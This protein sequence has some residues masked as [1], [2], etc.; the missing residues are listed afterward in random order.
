MST[1]NS[2]I[3]FPLLIWLHSSLVNY[4]ETKAPPLKA[5]FS[6]RIF[7]PVMLTAATALTVY[8]FLHPPQRRAVTMETDGF[9]FF[10]SC[11]LLSCIG[12]SCAIPVLP[13]GGPPDKV[14]PAIVES[15]PASE[16]VNVS[17]D[18]IRI[19]FS[20]FVDQASFAQSVSMTPAFDRPLQYRW[21]KKRVDITFPESL[22]ENTTYILNIDT[23]L[24][25]VNRIA[26]T[27]PITLAFAT[28]PIINR[29]RITGRVI[30]PQEGAGV[31][32]FDVFA[33]A[34]TDATL[35]DSLPPSPAYRTQTDEKGAFKFD[36][37][38][39]QAYFVIA[40]QDRNRNRKPDGL[41]AFAVPPEPVLL[42][43]S[44]GT[45]PSLSWLVTR[46]DTIPPQLQRIRSISNQRFMLRFS[47]SVQLLSR[48]PAQWSLKDSVSN[49]AYTIEDVYLYPEDPKQVY[50]KTP[51]LFA[52]THLLQPG[53]IA[54]SSGNPV[55]ATELTFKP[56]ANSDTLQL[57]F[58][59]F[60][61]EKLTNNEL[62]AAVLSP[63][64]RAGIRF[65]QSLCMGEEEL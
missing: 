26:L 40:L 10:V 15:N 18:G 16:S 6:R 50:L 48:D 51:P 58:L 52:T 9:L 22:R 63:G 27:E 65:N 3:R 20:E 47:E 37:M 17:T 39:E 59:G 4:A 34:L 49:Q 7:Q 28:G 44:A 21:R 57:R 19:V 64:Q 35:L 56:S 45:D 61:P 13:A 1:N 46:T 36:Y 14:P 54:D 12:L 38:S 25:D 43:D 42:A 60:Y 5:G 2:P 24:R 41:E 11:F 33:Y 29:G 53:G 31:A 32:K 23:D 62:G 55:S 8:L 30:E